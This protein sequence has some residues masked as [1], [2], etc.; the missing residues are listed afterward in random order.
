MRLDHLLSK[1]TLNI[2]RVVSHTRLDLKIGWL[3]STLY[4]EVNRR[5]SF[6]PIPTIYLIGAIRSV[7]NIF[8]RRY[9]NLAMPNFQESGPIAQLARAP[10]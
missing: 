7:N 9:E 10:C 3:R 1:E 5:V 4:G 2:S 6:W 8:F